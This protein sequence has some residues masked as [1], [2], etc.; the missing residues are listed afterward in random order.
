MSTMIR[1]IREQ[2]LIRD[3][4][5]QH[6]VDEH[7]RYEAQLEQLSKAPYVSAEDFLLEANLKKQKLRVKDE[8]ERRIALATKSSVSH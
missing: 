5:F 1:Q 2:L 6:L 4:E 7:S 8:I 3:A